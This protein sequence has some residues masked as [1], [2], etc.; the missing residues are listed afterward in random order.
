[1]ALRQQASSAAPDAAPAQTSPALSNLTT[2]QLM[3]LKRAAEYDAEANA[4]TASKEGG[5]GSALQDAWLGYGRGQEELGQG[6]KQLAEHAGAGLGIVPRETV[7]QTDADIAKTAKEY[8]RGVGSTTAAKVG[9]IVGQTATTLPLAALTGGGAEA[10]VL[11]NALRGA[12]AGAIA[13][14]AQPVTEGDYTTAKLENTGMGA[15][16]GGATSGGMSALKYLRPGNA[17]A[18]LLNTAAKGDAITAQQGADLAQRTGIDFTPAMTTGNKGQAQLENMARSSFFS[19]NNAFQT[20]SKIANQW[21][22]YVNNMLDNIHDGGGS[23]AEIGQRVQ[24]AVKNATKSLLDARDAQAAQDYGA[25]RSI[26]QNAATIQPQS[27]NAALQQLVAEQSGVGTPGADAIARFAQ[28]QLDNV[29]PAAQAVAD[30]IGGGAVADQAASLTAPGQGNLDKLM[31]LR[32]YLSKVAGGEAK[33]SGENYDRKVAAQ[34]LGTLDQDF[35]AASQSLPGDLGAALGKANANYRA[36]SQ[37]IEGLKNSALGKMVG[38]DFAN[39]IGGGTYN[40]IPPEM[41]MQRFSTMKPSQIEATKQV[42]Q[43]ADPDAWNAMKRGYLQAALDKAQTS[44]PS[45]GSKTL[46]ANTGA[47]VNMIAKTPQQ[48]RQLAAMF[49]PQDMAKV[50]DA[51]DAARRLADRTGANFSGTGA[52]VELGVLLSAIPRALFGDPTAIPQMVG[53]VAGPRAVAGA[54]ARNAGAAQVPQLPVL[55]KGLQA[56]QPYLATMAGANAAQPQQGVESP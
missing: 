8:A 16:M 22:G 55:P 2:D 34:L 7:D 45:A 41:V 33:I 42:L 39:A 49:E 23:P 14:G 24:G 1:M 50:N 37:Q 40:Q 26:T 19:R 54:M 18:D 31:Q 27:T 11:G 20:D 35:D 44:A 30:R 56:L 28:K 53:Q 32:S 5:T 10:G 48:Q 13:G 43:Q 21:V 4:A 3:H 46:P 6:I 12:T 15:L 51:L 38:D 25:V 47:F 9:D 29:N 17:A 36:S 52:R